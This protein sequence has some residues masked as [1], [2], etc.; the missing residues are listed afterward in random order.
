MGGKPESEISRA[1]TGNKRRE[2]KSLKKKKKNGGDTEERQV[3]Q[4]WRKEEEKD[5]KSGFTEK[6]KKENE[7][8]TSMHMKK[9]FSRRLTVAATQYFNMLLDPDRPGL[10]MCVSECVVLQ[11]TNC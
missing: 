10:E 4:V 2:G 7:R 3:G 9:H 8:G 5:R 11:A 1:I 6:N